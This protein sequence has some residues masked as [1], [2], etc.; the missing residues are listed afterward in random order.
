MAIDTNELI[1]ASHVRAIAGEMRTSARA[2][3]K[4]AQGLA[5]KDFQTVEVPYTEEERRLQDQQKQQNEDH[6]AAAKNFEADWNQQH[7]LLEF[8]PAA[9]QELAGIAKAIQAVN[10]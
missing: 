4:A 1:L 10:Q 5:H 9:Y 8:V 7:P 6:K 3:A 2:K